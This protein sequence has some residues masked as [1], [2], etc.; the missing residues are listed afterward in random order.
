M[1]KILALLALVALASAQSVHL[2][3]NANGF[4]WPASFNV[5]CLGGAFGCSAATCDCFNANVTGLCPPPPPPTPT[6]TNSP[7]PPTPPVVNHNPCSD[8]GVGITNAQVYFCLAQVGIAKIATSL[9]IDGSLT[10]VALYYNVSVQEYTAIQQTCDTVF[11]NTSCTFHSSQWTRSLGGFT[12][13]IAVGGNQTIPAITVAP[14]NSAS[15]FFGAQPN[16]QLT[17]GPSLGAATSQCC[18]LP[19]PGQPSTIVNNCSTVVAPTPTPTPTTTAP[20]TS[21]PTTAGPTPTTSTGPT[22]TTSTGPTPTTSTGPTPTTAGPTPTTTVPTRSTD[23]TKLVVAGAA[24]LA[25]IVL[26]L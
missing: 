2:N 8:L 14:Q 25:A 20:T 12:G 5:S 19:V 1:F 6:P 9:C 23:A 11:V 17:L 22:P 21:A 18:R 26:A 15:F 7:T 3:N 4:S 16:C 24:V 13:S 10:F